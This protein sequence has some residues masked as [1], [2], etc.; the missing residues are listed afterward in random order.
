MCPIERD[1]LIHGCARLSDYDAD[2][3]VSMNLRRLISDMYGGEDFSI[4][5]WPQ[6]D[7]QDTFWWYER[8]VNIPGAAASYMLRIDNHRGPNLYAGI[9]VEKSYEDREKA[10]AKAGTKNEPVERFLL[11]STWDWHRLLSSWRQ[12]ES[13]VVDAAVTSE[14]ELYLWFE[15]ANGQRDSRYYVVRQGRLYGR[16]GRFEPVSWDEP[17]VFLQAPR[18]KY[19]GTTSIVRVFSIDECD[20]GVD[21]NAIIE[22]FRALRPVRDLW[23]DTVA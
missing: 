22:V 5:S 19:W 12:L 9:S 2:E 10:T 21:E 13:L 16:G 3:R 1:W 15:F 18:A 6:R 23:R 14:T 17:H 4:G 8:N 7:F 20:C 11:D